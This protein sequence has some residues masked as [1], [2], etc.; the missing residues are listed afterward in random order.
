VNKEGK[1]HGFF[2]SFSRK[3]GRRISWGNFKNG[4]RDG[5]WTW[6]FEDGTP[7][8]VQSFA[9]G[10]KKAFWLPAESWG[11]EHGEYKR[12]FYNGKLEE[13][14][15]Y[16]SGLKDGSWI[17]YHPNG[18]LEYR[19][20]YLDGKKTGGWEYYYPS[21]IQEAMEEFD[22]SGNLVVRLTYYPNGDLWCKVVGKNSAICKD[23]PG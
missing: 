18:K 21:G 8:I 17:K 2:E 7:Y 19:G 14:G 23:P 1:Y 5:E 9:Y 3:D 10:K 4:Q 16:D 12:F 22:K 20:Q 15:N 6:T 13:K 11:N